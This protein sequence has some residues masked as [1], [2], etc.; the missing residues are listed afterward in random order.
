MTSGRKSKEL[1]PERYASTLAELRTWKS[2]DRERLFRELNAGEYTTLEELAGTLGVCWRTVQRAVK[3]GSIDAV[4]VGRRWVVT[5][6]EAERIAK[7]GF[8][9]SRGGGE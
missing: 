9:T 1:T 5:R 6:E 2:V 4:K 3:A 8:H 7:E